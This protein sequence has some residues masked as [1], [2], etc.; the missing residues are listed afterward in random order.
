MLDVF[1]VAFLPRDHAL[2]VAIMS[3]NGHMNVGLL[4]DYDAMPD[5]DVVADGIEAA[6]AELVERARR[7]RGEAAGPAGNGRAGAS[8]RA[9]TSA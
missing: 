5:I 9:R 3:Y 7:E 1:P 8:R 4:G 2:A 6:L